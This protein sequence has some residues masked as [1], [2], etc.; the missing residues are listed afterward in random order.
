MKTKQI[1]LYGVIVIILLFG[2]W[3]L[4]KHYGPKPVLG[5]DR[6][7]HGCIGS[8]GYTWCGIK[9]KCL[10]IWEDDCSNSTDA[11]R[12]TIEEALNIAVKSVCTAKGNLTQ[13]YGYNINSRTWWIN[14]A[15]KPEFAK[16]MCNPVCVVSENKAAEINWRC[17]GLILPKQTECLPQQRG[18]VACTM[19]YA[20]VCGSNG[21][22]YGNK[23]TACADEKVEYYTEGECTEVAEV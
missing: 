2:V 16:D 22:T 9:Q 5:G 17:T 8:A 3:T 19:E 6:D 13:N 11:K 15:M 4:K 14:L 12:M 18:A 20:P 1:I 7:E 23:C 10:R 21:R